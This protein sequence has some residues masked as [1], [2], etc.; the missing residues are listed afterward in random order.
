MDSITLFCL[1]HRSFLTFVFATTSSILFV[2]IGVAFFP[3]DEGIHFNKQMKIGILGVFVLFCA[4]LSFLGFAFGAKHTDA[5][6]S[7][8]ERLSPL[9]KTYIRKN[10]AYSPITI[11]DFNRINQ[12]YARWLKRKADCHRFRSDYEQSI[13]LGEKPDVPEHCLKKFEINRK[14]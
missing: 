13:A 14:K 1:Q 9:E 6:A 11:Y 7:W 12:R 5:P 4:S 2:V 10:V 3:D 8:L